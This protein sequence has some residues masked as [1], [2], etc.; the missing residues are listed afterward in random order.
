M[1]AGDSI[2][3]PLAG[4]ARVRSGRAQNGSRTIRFGCVNVSDDYGDDVDGSSDAHTHNER[5]GGREM[6]AEMEAEG[7]RERGWLT[8][9][10]DG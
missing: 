8:E 10:M 3:R 2:G 4:S 5:E 1:G 9:A 6:R 7:G